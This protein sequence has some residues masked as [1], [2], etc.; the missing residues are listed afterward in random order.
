MKRDSLGL[1]AARGE[2]RG[3]IAMSSAVQSL[4][5]TPNVLMQFATARLS[6]GRSNSSAVPSTAG[7]TG[8]TVE[9]YVTAVFEALAVFRFLPYATGPAVYDDADGDGIEDMVD[10][11]FIGGTLADDSLAFSSGF[12]DEHL[13]GTSSGTADDRGGLVVIVRDAPSP[14]GFLLGASGGAGAATITAC[15]NVMQLA[16]G[17]FVTVTCD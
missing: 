11:R 4:R 7:E 14:L 1:P 2:P 6:G 10:G 16:V 13:G 5:R 12:T 3:R 15:G 17:E 8:A 9:S